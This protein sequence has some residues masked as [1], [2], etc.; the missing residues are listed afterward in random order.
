MPDSYNVKVKI[1][2]VGDAKVG[3]TSLV[4]RYVMDMYS[5]E[6][7]A[8]LGTKISKKN[9]IIKRNNN[10]IN[11]TLSI[12]DVLGQKELKNIQK[13]AFQGAKGAMFVC[14]ITRGET[15]ESVL[16]WISEVTKVTGEIPIILLANKC[17]LTDEYAF[18]EEN[19]KIYSSEL[20]AP[21]FLT[22]AKYGDNVIKTFFRI[23]NLIIDNIFVQ[24]SNQVSKG[25]KLANAT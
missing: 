17:D 7:I 20:N 2:L 24:D 10:E 18:S 5:D 12:W 22:S 25:I 1:C 6:Y 13:M 14:D 15:L 11:L 19:I 21:Y 8:T 23:G 3:K 4:R 16:T 9:L